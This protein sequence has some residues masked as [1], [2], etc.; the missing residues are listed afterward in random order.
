MRDDDI[1]MKA[2]LFA[3]GAKGMFLQRYHNA[4]HDIYMEVN[5]ARGM[6]TTR[7]W[8]S[9]KLPDLEFKTLTELQ[10]ALKEL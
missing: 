10:D 1:I 5:G 8:F 7:T 2:I 6:P 3:D 9:P 4:E